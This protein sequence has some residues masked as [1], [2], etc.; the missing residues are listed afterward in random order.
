LRHTSV[1]KFE[2][3]RRTRAH[4]GSAFGSNTTHCKPRSTLASMKISRR[5]T[6]TY[7]Q[8]ESL[9]MTRPPYTRMPRLFGRKSRITLML[10]G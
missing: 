9:V 7:F 5:L 4:S 10:T 1:R 2:I 6:F 3:E 8:S